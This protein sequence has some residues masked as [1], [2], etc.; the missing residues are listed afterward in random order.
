MAAFNYENCTPENT[1]EIIEYS[2]IEQRR[3][4]F[5]FA[6]SILIFPATYYFVFFK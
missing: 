4:W 3:A 5:F 6:L 2:N 1:V